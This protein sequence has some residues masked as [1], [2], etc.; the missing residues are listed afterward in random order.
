MC[1]GQVSPG[2]WLLAGL[3]PAG[4][5]PHDA[6]APLPCG[7]RQP[8][9]PAARAGLSGMLEEWLEVSWCVPK[10]SMHPRPGNYELHPRF[11]QC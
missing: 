1:V 3:H 6:A 10:G 2:A 8:R 5:A 7:P 11:T 4:L 9:L